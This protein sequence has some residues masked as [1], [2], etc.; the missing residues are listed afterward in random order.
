VTTVAIVGAGASGLTLAALLHRAGVDF[1]VLE[2]RSR[3]YVE[4]RQRA[5]VL[6][7]YAGQVYVTAGLTEPVLGGVPADGLLEIRYDG[8]PRFLNVPELTGGG[9]G[10]L[11]PQQLLVRLDR[12]FSSPP[13]AAAFA[14]LMAGIQ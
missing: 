12:L 11:V 5:G 14:D 2:A 9:H 4:Q 1:V 8:A 7:H 6:D 13:A 10:Y 3:S